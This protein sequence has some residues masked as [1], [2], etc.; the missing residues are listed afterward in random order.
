MAVFEVDPM[1]WLPWGHEI[2]DGGPTRLPHTLYYMSQDPP[3]RHLSYCIAMVEPP[4]AMALWREQVHDFLTRL[5]QRNVYHTWNSNDPVTDRVLVYASFPSPQF[6][7]RDV[8]FG[9]FASVGGVKE[10]WIAPVYILMVDFANALPADEDQMPPDGNPHPFPGELQPNNNVF[11]NPQFPEI[12]WDAVENLGHEQQGGQGGNDDWNQ[13]EDVPEVVQEVNESMV[14]NLSDTSSS[15]V[16]M[17]EVQLQQQGNMQ[18][19]Y[20]VLNVGTVQTVIGHVLPPEMLWARALLLVLPSMYGKLV[21]EAKVVSPFAFLKKLSGF[22]LSVLAMEM[23]GDK[24]HPIQ[25]RPRMFTLSVPHREV[26]S[27]AEESVGQTDTQL[28]AVDLSMSVTVRKRK[29]RKAAAPLVQSIERRFTRS[30]LKIDGY[31]AKPILAIQP[32]IKK[33]SRAKNL[34]MLLEKEAQQQEQGEE[35]GNEEQAQVPI[36]PIAVMQRVGLALGIAPEK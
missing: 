33:K 32:K 27:I 1:P 16:N 14:I 19:L 13:M 29:M 25:S 6:V 23:E 3:A 5:L 35:Q 34:L 12:G 8:V 7:A 28:G 24:Q 36:T 9:K 20:N 22:P 2:I 4:P 17:M 31:R 10:S 11:V 18:L 21:P 26:M 30:Y 15:S